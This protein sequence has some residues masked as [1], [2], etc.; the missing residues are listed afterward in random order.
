[1]V[2]SNSALRGIFQVQGVASQAKPAV[3]RTAAPL[4]SLL[5][6]KASPARRG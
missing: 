1:M 6:V 4:G 5:T 2:T 3:V